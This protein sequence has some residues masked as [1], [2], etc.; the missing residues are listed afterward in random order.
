M[1]ELCLPSPIFLHG[2]VRNS[3][4]NSAQGQ[5]RLLDTGTN[6]EAPHCA[7]VSSFPSV[8]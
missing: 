5:L 1:V 6:Y 3:L 4:I 2:L 7:T 8:S